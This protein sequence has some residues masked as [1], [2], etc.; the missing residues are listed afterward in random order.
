VIDAS[1]VRA[2]STALLLHRN[3][4]IGLVAALQFRRF[5]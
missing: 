3:A 2:M 5:S 4:E 1:W